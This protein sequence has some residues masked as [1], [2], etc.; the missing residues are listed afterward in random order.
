MPIR[1]GFALAIAGAV[2]L[3]IALAGIL[4]ADPFDGLARAFADGALCLIGFALLGRPLGLR[5]ST[6]Q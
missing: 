5:R 1:G 3:C 6:L 2:A 4:Q